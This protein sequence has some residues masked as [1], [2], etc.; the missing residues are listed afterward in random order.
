VP[1]RICRTYYGVPIPPE[2]ETEFAHWAIA[3]SVYMFAD[4][5]G[6]PAYRRIAHAAGDRMRPLLDA[7]IADAKGDAGG[8]DTVVAR[9]VKMQHADPAITDDVIRGHLLGM[10]TGFVPTNTIAA[11]HMLEVLVGGGSIMHWNRTKF[12][13]PARDALRL[14]DDDL[15]TRCLLETSRFKPI[16]FGPFRVTERDYTISDG[17]FAGR[18]PKTIPKGSKLLV[19][20]HS[21]MFDGRRIRNRYRFDPDRAPSDYMLFGSGIHVCLGLFLAKAQI[22]QTLKPLLAQKNLRR[23]P[24]DAGKLQRVGP[25]PAH[26]WVE[27]DR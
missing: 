27:Y 21:A 26:L 24:G 12:M 13:A 5:T 23:A 22:T 25:F 15:L 18:R 6:N 7:A 11:G 20:T 10:I 14:H 4:P 2:Q 8:R 17:G 1:T 3:M 19:S 9:L 16:N